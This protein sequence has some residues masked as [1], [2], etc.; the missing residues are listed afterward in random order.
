MNARVFTTI[1]KVSL[2]RLS[3]F[4]QVG[5]GFVSEDCTRKYTCVNDGATSFLAEQALPGCS[6][7]ENCEKADGDRQCIC[8][9]GFIRVSGICKG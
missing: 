5:A 1:K 3:C 8:K 7:N 4:L 6:Q 9:E 2:F